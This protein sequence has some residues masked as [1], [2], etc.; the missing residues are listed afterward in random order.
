MTAV[1][2]S[3]ESNQ[4]TEQ[5]TIERREAALK[6]MLNTPPQPHKPLGKPKLKASPSQKKRGLPKKKGET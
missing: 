6:R 2:P 3:K 4:Y 1:V 5:E